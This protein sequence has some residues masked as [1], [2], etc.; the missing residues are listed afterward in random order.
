MS[1]IDKISKFVSVHPMPLEGRGWLVVLAV[2]LVVLGCAHSSIL[3][4]VSTRRD[5]VWWIVVVTGLP[6]LGMAVY[7]AALVRLRL[8]AGFA[9]D[10]P[11]EAR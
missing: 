11:G 4:M 6:V 7:L 1:L 3:R 9:G 5:R 8:R 2:W 10:P